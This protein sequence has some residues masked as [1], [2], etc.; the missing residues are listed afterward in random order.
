MGK[1][2]RKKAV[3]T[4]KSSPASP[5]SVNNRPSLTKPSQ[6][7]ANIG[8]RRFSM[9]DTTSPATLSEVST[10]ATSGSG[11]DEDV[12]NVETSLGATE[13]SDS[14]SRSSSKK[15]T[16]SSVRLGLIPEAPADCK[17]TD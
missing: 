8:I 16:T 3:P 2:W 5:R 15:A 10:S 1:A 7:I 9:M 12:N 14:T 17:K 11:S 6:T 4:Q 13:D